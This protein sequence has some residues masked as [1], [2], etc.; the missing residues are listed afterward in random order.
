M[1]GWLHCR[2]ATRR[3]PPGRTSRHFQPC[4]IVP[5]RRSQNGRGN[6]VE[7][8]RRLHRFLDEA[9]LSRPSYGPRSGQHFVS[10]FLQQPAHPGRMRS[11]LQSYPGRC[12]RFKLLSHPRGCGR[13]PSSF[14]YLAWP[15]HHTELTEPISQ[16]QPNDPTDFLALLCH[17]QS[18]L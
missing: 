18:P 10:Q 12:Y 14:H 4:P 8:Q 7:H 15:I 2:P 3:W 1:P 5:I 6:S 16:I 13:H 17:G 9:V 11:R